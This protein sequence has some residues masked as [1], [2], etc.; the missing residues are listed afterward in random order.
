MKQKQKRVRRNKGVKLSNK[1]NKEEQKSFERRDKELVDAIGVL[2][3]EMNKLNERAQLVRD[4]IKENVGRRSELRN[5][6]GIDT[7]DKKKEETTRD[8]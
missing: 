4:K 7:E 2:V 5:I 1:L 8:G 6:Y 3:E